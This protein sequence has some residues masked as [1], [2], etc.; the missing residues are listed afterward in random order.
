MTLISD[1]IIDNLKRVAV[2]SDV[3]H[4]HAAGILIGKKLIN[5]YCNKFSKRLSIDRSFEKSTHAEINSIYSYL[6]LISPRNRNNVPINILVIRVK[7]NILR[8]SRPC[9]ICI[10]KMKKIGINKVYYSNNNGIIVYEYITD[11]H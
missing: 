4:Q 1:D 7:N 8:N 2:H 6:T 11:M 5:P 3:T 10:L 9:N